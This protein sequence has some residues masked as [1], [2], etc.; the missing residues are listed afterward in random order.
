MD[1][2]DHQ[3]LEED[4]SAD[5]IESQDATQVSDFPADALL[6]NLPGDRYRVIEEIARGGM[7]VV[8]RAYD[9]SFDRTLAIKVMLTRS[10]VDAER[11]FLEEAR[12]TGQLQ[13]PGIPPAHELGRLDDGRPYFSMKLIEG[14]T[15][16][17]L[18]RQRSSPASELPRFLKAFEQIAQTLA[19]AHSRGVIHRDLKPLNIMVGAFGE[20]QVM[21]WGLAKRLPRKTTEIAELSPAVPDAA[22]DRSAAPADTVA[23]ADT[24]PLD[25]QTDDSQTQAGQVLGTISYM[26]PE[27]ARGEVSALDERCDVFG[28]GGILCTILTGQPPYPGNDKH[29]LRKQAREGDLADARARL[30]A[31]GAD[32]QLVTL[33]LSC[34]APQKADRP[35]HA[36]EVA[37]AI[38]RYL[39]SVEQQLHE[40]RLAR[41]EAEIRAG[42]ERKRRRLAVGLAAAVVV[43]VVGVGAASLWYVRDQ[44]RRQAE[45][46]ARRDFLDREVGAALDETERRRSDLHQ[47]LEDGHEAAQLLSELDGWQDLVASA[48]GAWTRAD[49]IAAGGGEMLSSQLRER[50]ATVAGDLQADERDRELAF[51]LD[52]I[53]LEV[54]TPVNGGLDLS[55]GVPLLIGALRDAG[56]DIERQDPAQLAE[57]LRE[58]AIRIPLVATLDFLAQITDDENQRAQILQVA[59]QADVDSWRDGFRQPTVWDNRDRLKA[60]ATDV[61]SGGQTP[62][63]L[64]ALAVRTNTLN[65]AS[66]SVALL[67]RALVH[68]PRDFWL[69]YL[70]GIYSSNPAEQIGAF[71]AA[72]AVRPHSAIAF[73]SLG[74]V[75]YADQQLAEALACYR[76]AVEL[77]KDYVSAHSNLGLVLSDTGHADEAIDCFR[78]A[79]ELDPQ[80]VFAQINLGAVLQEQ[81]KWDE[82]A[83]WYRRAIEIDPNSEAAN[84][85]LGTVLRTQ[86][87]L[88][89]AIAR[90]RRTTE[91]NPKHAKAWCNLGHALRQQG[92]LAEALPAFRQGHE[93]GSATKGWSHPSGQWVEETERYVALEQKLP[94]ILRGEATPADAREQLDLAE[95]CQIYKKQFA[96]AARF[97]AAALVAEP[98]LALDVSKG[99]RYNAACA[100]A[101]ASAG[102]GVDGAELSDAERT[103]F[104][105]QALSWLQA[106]LGAWWLASKLSSQSAD[107]VV[108]TLEHWQ[109]D[110]DLADV[111]DPAALDAL[112]D[113]EQKP[114]QKL[115]SDVSAL[116][117]R[118]AEKSARK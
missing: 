32:A 38:T 53:R 44:G 1:R 39:A 4:E 66:S 15:L 3:R 59:R 91:I 98:M 93:L 109:T 114:W 5:L 63:I 65:G 55:R 7:G 52:R 115:W 27:Q 51:E 57:R 102:R 62:Q 83:D 118:Q 24:A 20:V 73:Y 81:E 108:K 96:A 6:R 2:R 33:A 43:L 13:H 34:L 10:G 107:A 113:D 12:V 46:A 41:A 72:L 35:R 60:L 40:A 23:P 26:A 79:L 9:V 29:L 68:H 95:L 47:R 111:R 17:E 19:F 99:R 88:D 82:A 76:K 70:L 110:P 78:R 50:L 77:N 31:C 74:V 22:A 106:D 16:A 64:S 100:A 30:E 58:S 112:P 80:H 56:F 116:V 45:A 54:S 21:D 11:R 36:G 94:A 84:N 75:H 48:Q 103:E 117:S 87:R 61:D 105:R 49:R 42:E 89:E 101:Q 28:L 37:E 90:F 69:L 18:L 97:Y 104:R 67:R 86:S 25:S 14:R 71:R 8:L 92:S 85:N